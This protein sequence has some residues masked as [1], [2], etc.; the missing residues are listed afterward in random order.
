MIFRNIY[1]EYKELKKEHDY[2][3]RECYLKEEKI[4]ELKK[5]IKELTKEKPK[6]G[7]PR[8]EVKND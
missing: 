3:A 2:Y 8:K 1:K 5:Q 4:R 7:R 6:R